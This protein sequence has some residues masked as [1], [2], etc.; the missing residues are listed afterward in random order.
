M[1]SQLALGI[2]KSGTSALYAALE[3]ALP[4][5]LCL[6]EP[7]FEQQMQFLRQARHDHKLTKILYA[8]MIDRPWVLSFSTRSYTLC[9]IRGTCSLASSSIGPCLVP[10]QGSGVYRRIVQFT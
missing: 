9:A 8:F 7:V 2:A 6:F 4:D 1:A 3:K 5:P 10:G